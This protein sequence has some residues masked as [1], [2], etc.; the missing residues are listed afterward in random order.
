MMAAPPLLT[1]MVNTMHLCKVA[2][3]HARLPL[4]DANAGAAAAT[5]QLHGLIP[6]A[7]QGFL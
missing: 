7:V 6:S 4:A 5:G 2:E 1:G 3:G